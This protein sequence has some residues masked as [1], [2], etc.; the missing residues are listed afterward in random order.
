MCE[1]NH[2]VEVPAF[3]LHIKVWAIDRSVWDFK[4]KFQIIEEPNSRRRLPKSSVLQKPVKKGQSF[5][6]WGA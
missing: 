2:A 6:Y 4:K 1:G 3:V 5:T